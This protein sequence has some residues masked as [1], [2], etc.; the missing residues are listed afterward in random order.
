MSLIATP[1]AMR[2]VGQLGQ[3]L[4]PRGLMPNPKDGTVTADVAGA[5]KNAKSG[6]VRYR[7][8]K[9]GIVHCTIGK[10][11]FDVAD[12]TQNLEAILAALK[13]AKPN[14][15]K[16]VFTLKKL[17]FPAPWAQVC[18]LI[19]QVLQC[20]IEVSLPNVSIFVGESK[21]LCGLLTKVS[22]RQ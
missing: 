13:K 8:D 20:K 11:D 10:I 1:D 9:G 5:V 4:G 22:L 2:V 3:V 12:F 6:Q 16:R 18:K 14:Q 21:K 7:T 15:C 17:L 19:Y